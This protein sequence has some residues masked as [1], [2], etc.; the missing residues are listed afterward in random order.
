MTI[1]ER[2]G[3][4]TVQNEE[5][6]KDLLREFLIHHGYEIL[7]DVEGHLQVK[8]SSG[9]I[10]TFK[11]RK[12]VGHETMEGELPNGQKFQLKEK[13]PNYT[14]FFVQAIYSSDPNSLQGSQEFKFPEQKSMLMAVITPI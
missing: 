1:S 10:L 13:N 6:T 11:L 3:N 14:G 5:S 12:S 9:K 8:D 7:P 4:M 2:T